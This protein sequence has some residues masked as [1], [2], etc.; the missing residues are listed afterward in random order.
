MSSGKS[1]FTAPADE[2][3]RAANAG[4]KLAIRQAA[5]AD[6]ASVAL[7]YNHYVTKTTATF[8]TE[9]VHPAVM[10]DRIKQCRGLGLPWLLAEQEGSVLGYAYAVPWKPRQAYRHS[11]E[12]TIYM[13]DEQIG[14]GIGTRLY[15]A[16]LERLEALG[17]HTAIGGIAL[18]NP[19]SVALH[20]TLGFEK[21]A[22]FREVGFK[23][24]RWVDVG[25]WQKMLGP[26][27]ADPAVPVSDADG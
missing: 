11:C 21:M 20:E 3:R 18:P 1:A 15:A 14:R 22:H 9:P 13:R 16:L 26:D 19:A 8:E 7:I 27:Q 17:C 4:P 10:A 24:N 2:G 6:A 5:A 23:L 25:Y 12:T